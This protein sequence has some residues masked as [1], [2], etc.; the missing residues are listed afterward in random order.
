M[1]HSL[2]P[3]IVVLPV[4]V[5]EPVQAMLKAFEALDMSPKEC[6]IVPLDVRQ[7]P[8]R[9]NLLSIS[10]AMA[11]GGCITAWMWKD[12]KQQLIRRHTKS[13]DLNHVYVCSFIVYSTS[14]PYHMW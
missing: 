5:V 2:P 13:W 6:Q 8:L 1:M 10:N 7:P 11:T 12:T 14:G 3:S 4:S 9:I